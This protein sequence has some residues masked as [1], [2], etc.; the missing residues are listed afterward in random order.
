[1]SYLLRGRG[2]DKGAEA[3]GAAVALS[4]GLGAVNRTGIVEGINNIPGVSNVSFGTDG[5]AQDTT[6]TVGGYLGERIYLAYGVGV[7]EPINVL[8][9]RL[10]L[11]T[12]LWLEIV[13]SLQ[14]SV[15]V[16]YSF[17]IK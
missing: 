10:Y 5:Q 11:Q 6:A 8:T 16:Y 4:L 14:S 12:R 2:L 1:M 17:D 15:D 9:A 13:S 3:D 7:Y